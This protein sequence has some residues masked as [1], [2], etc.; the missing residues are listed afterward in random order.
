M[1]RA[2]ALSLYRNAFRLCALHDR[3]P[4]LKSYL[5]R[6]PTADYDR[7]TAVWYELSETQLRNARE[8]H[9]IQLEPDAPLELVSIVSSILQ[10]GDRYRPTVSLR[11]ELRKHAKLKARNKHQEK[12]S[13]KFQKTTQGG[14]F[15]VILA[16]SRFLNENV[17]VAC[18]DLKI[19][20]KVLRK[21]TQSLKQVFKKN[22]CPKHILDMREHYK[23]ILRGGL[24]AAESP[25]DEEANLLLAHPTLLKNSDEERE[26]EFDDSAILVFK[27]HQGDYGLVLNKPSRYVLG[28]LLDQKTSNKPNSDGEAVRRA[29]GNNRMYWGG[30]VGSNDSFLALH[31]FEEL[32]AMKVL[33]GLYLGGC[34]LPEALQLLN[35]GREVSVVTSSSHGVPNVSKRRAQASDFKFF[36]G[37]CTWGK[38]QLDGECQRNTWFRAKT[39]HSSDLIELAQTLLTSVPAPGERRRRT[40]KA[41]SDSLPLFPA[42]TGNE[43]SVIGLHL[44]ESREGIDEKGDGEQ[45][46]NQRKSIRKPLFGREELSFRRAVWDV[47]MLRLGGEHAEMTKR[48]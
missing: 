38:N 12:F 48:P 2:L 43:Q 15:E 24:S 17:S 45:D 22:L 9:T 35:S 21:G 8:K 42:Q 36:F 32:G 44:A 31:P 16:V 10:T 25:Y 19:S 3:F 34:S 27:Q 23:G 29:F 1:S 13:Q 11:D 46:E 47:C 39:K 20:A 14:D 37:F 40:G 18:K 30:P 41:A 4:V 33:D 7:E 28:D 5:T 26:L 6:M